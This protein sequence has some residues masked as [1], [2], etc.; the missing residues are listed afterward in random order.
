MV[1]IDWLSWTWWPT[2]MNGLT[3][4]PKDGGSRTRT[5]AQ[6]GDAWAASQPLEPRLMMA[7]DVLTY[8]NDNTGDGANLK[9]TT[10]TTGNVNPYTF[11]KLGQVAVD[12]NVYAQPLVKTNVRSGQGRPK[13]G[14]R[15]HR[16]RQRLRLRRQQPGPGL[17]RQLHQPRGRRS[18]RCPA[19]GS[20]RATSAPR[21]A[22]P[23]PRSSTPGRTRSTSSPSRQITSPSGGVS[24]QQQLH[25]ID[26]ARAGRRWAGR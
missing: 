4:R 22:S 13:R 5:R 9:E 2:L 20:A 26:L 18:P 12:G 7:A 21:S 14:L 10:L 1:S 23:A 25:A 17:A 19:R 16:A 3:R 15:G 8:R 11:G 6:V 24:F